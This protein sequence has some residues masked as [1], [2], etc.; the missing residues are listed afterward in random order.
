MKMRRLLLSA[1]TVL[2]LVAVACVNLDEIT[3][4]AATAS[5]ADSALSNLA[6]DLLESCKCLNA[7]K[8]PGE[9]PLDCM[10]YDHRKD[11]IAAQSALLNY[12][13]ALGNLAS[14][15]L[16]TFQ[17]NLTDMDTKLKGAGFD[18]S[19]VKATSSLASAALEA[20]VKGYRG[21]KLGGSYRSE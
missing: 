19:Q 5:S 2:L 8:P 1:T 16:T 10:P 3:K 14:D 4:F 7:Y 15:K 6:T 17:G 21:K 18:D 12:V 13:Q 9:T 11:L 20:M